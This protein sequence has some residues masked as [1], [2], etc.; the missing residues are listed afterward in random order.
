MNSFLAFF[1]AGSSLQ[2]LLTVGFPEFLKYSFY[3]AMLLLN[4]P[5]YTIIIICIGDV[6]EAKNN[7]HI[8]FLMM[9]E[10]MDI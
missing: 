9:N 10:E 2:S 4:T 7:L 8:L 3:H 1:C 6:K 5:A